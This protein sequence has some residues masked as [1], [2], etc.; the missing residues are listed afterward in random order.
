MWLQRRICGA[1]IR[2]W[3]HK[4]RVQCFCADSGYGMLA[5]TQ[6]AVYDGSFD[7][8][9]LYMAIRRAIEAHRE[10]LPIRNMPMTAAGSQVSQ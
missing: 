7:T 6:M 3:I 1:W 4:D 9:Q 8:L 5:L 10:R 2:Q